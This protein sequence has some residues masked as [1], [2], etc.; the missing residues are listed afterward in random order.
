MRRSR[1]VLFLCLV[2]ATLMQA[3]TADA[4]VVVTVTPNSG[5]SSGDV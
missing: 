5:L 4:D 1:I 2:C 3:A